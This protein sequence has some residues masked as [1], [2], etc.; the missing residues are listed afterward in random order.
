M[1][2]PAVIKMNTLKKRKKQNAQNWKVNQFIS[3]LSTP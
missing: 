3:E 1:K 2:Y